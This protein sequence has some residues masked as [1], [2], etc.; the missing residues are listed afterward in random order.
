[1]SLIKL[2]ST[3]YEVEKQAA[4]E[5]HKTKKSEG[6]NTKK[7][8]AS[9]GLGAAL[10]AAALG[11][12]AYAAT[13]NKNIA[14]LAALD[15]ILAGTQLGEGVSKYKQIKAHAKKEGRNHPT[16]RALF[17]PQA[18]LRMQGDTPIKESLKQLDLGGGILGAINR[19]VRKPDPE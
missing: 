8:W 14:G 7:I 18:S 15:G 17:N 5:F 3:S 1:M 12:A 9:R 13:K 6:Y 4:S 10:G 16:L 11:G 2:A 19:K